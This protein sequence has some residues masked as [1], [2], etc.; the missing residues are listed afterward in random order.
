MLR[1][2]S[3]VWQAGQIISENN[4]QRDAS[5]QALIE[6]FGGRRS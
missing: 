3:I 2:D 6:Y 4:D 1:I 5:R